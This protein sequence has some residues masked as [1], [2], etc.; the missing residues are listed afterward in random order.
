MATDYMDGTNGMKKNTKKALKLCKRA[1]ELGNTSAQNM[2]A[3]Y[4]YLGVVGAVP[5][6]DQKA[7]YYAEKAADQG[8]VHSQFILADLLAEDS[9]GN[10]EEEIFRLFTLAAFQ[11]SWGGRFALAMYYNKKYDS[12]RIFG[13]S[14]KDSRR[15]RFLS[16]YWCGKA[17][18]VEVKDPKGS[19][20]LAAMALHLHQAMTHVW[21]RPPRGNSPCTI[22]PNPGYSHVPFIT[23]ALAKG[24]AFTDEF[25]H[26]RPFDYYWRRGC[27]NCG[28]REKA[29]LKACARCKS[30]HYC[31][32]KCQVEHWKAGH[33]V[34]CKGHWIEKYFPNIRN[35][36]APHLR[37]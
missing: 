27:A 25:Y 1:A 28:S 9:G 12:M 26:G 10:D 30:F 7:R 2:L 33:K 22:D 5:K 17:A 6:C 29:H 24:G 13:N 37:Y 31:S 15:N 4:Y 35:G 19:R 16:I 20:S 34:D 23:W 32:K 21:H 14:D 8:A 3:D 18:E 36:N 11:G